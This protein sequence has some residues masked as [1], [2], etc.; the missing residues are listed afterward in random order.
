MHVRDYITV[1]KILDLDVIGVI[2]HWKFTD[3]EDNTRIDEID[4]IGNVSL[5]FV[6]YTR[7]LVLDRLL[8]CVFIHV[9]LSLFDVMFH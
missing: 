5:T 6:C 8:L 4:E 9:I 1:Q 3:Y 7:I 2:F